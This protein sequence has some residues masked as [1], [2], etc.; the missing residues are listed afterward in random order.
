MQTG[1]IV[2][3]QGKMDNFAVEPT[4]YVDAE[5][6]RAGF[7]PYAEKLN[8]RLAMLGFLSMLLLEGLTGHGLVEL[9][10]SL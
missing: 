1:T 9:F 10:A 3:E 2:D 8:G 7:T 6:S 4:M 5:G